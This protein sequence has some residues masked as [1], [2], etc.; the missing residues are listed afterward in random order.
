MP[1]QIFKTQIPTLTLFD[2]LS[3]VCNTSEDL[4]VFNY[5][6]FK[7]ANLLRLVEPFIQEIREHYYT[8][9]QMYVNRKQTYTTFITIVRQICKHNK[10]SYTTKLIYD[11][12]KYEI[13]YYI[14][15][16]LPIE[17]TETT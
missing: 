13:I 5:A 3:S 16:T 11:K 1:S 10:L 4:F 8:S 2:F 14:S 9:K 17:I 7:K 6:A 12:S 15:N